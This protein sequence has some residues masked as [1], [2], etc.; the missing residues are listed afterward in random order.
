VAGFGAGWLANPGTEAA[1]RSNRP[2]RLVNSVDFIG[3]G[4]GSE[5]LAKALIETERR[6]GLLG[7][8]GDGLRRSHDKIFQPPPIEWITNRL[9]NLQEVLEKR[10]A[11]SVQ[12]LRGLLGPITLQPVTP[13]IGRAS[14]GPQ[15]RSTHSPSSKHPPTETV[16]RAV[17]I[18]CGGGDGGN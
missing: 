12:T 13:E 1:G 5:A 6:V 4:R 10:T 11:L 16:R 14:I 17:R 15:Q 3:A 18:L 9:D 7:D 8:A 2:R